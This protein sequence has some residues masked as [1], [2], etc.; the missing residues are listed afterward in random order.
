[1][2]ENN[3]EDIIKVLKKEISQVT[4]LF[5][6]LS[7]G[8]LILLSLMAFEI[9]PTIIGMVSA[10]CLIF[11]LLIMLPKINLYNNDIQSLKRNELNC[12]EG[13]LLAVFKSDDTISDEWMIFVNSGNQE[14]LQFEIGA[15]IAK[16]LA[17]GD[18][19]NILYTPNNKIIV[20]FDVI[21]KI[22]NN[23]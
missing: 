17:E 11:I 23:K 2:I 8:V 16:D 22:V 12:L 18:V 21:R 5:Y 20:T 4:A 10:L 9:I 14:Y 13:D 3:I 6:G 7:L 15:Q 1:M 19:V